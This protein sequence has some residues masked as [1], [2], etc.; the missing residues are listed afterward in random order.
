M[1]P[2]LSFEFETI[3]D[4]QDFLE[5]ASAFI[6]SQKENVSGLVE[7]EPVGEVLTS[8]LTTPNESI[9]QAEVDTPE[10]E[11]TPGDSRH[12]ITR[13]DVHKALRDYKAKNGHPEY[14][15]LLAYFGASGLKDIVK[16]DYKA[17]YDMAMG[18]PTEPGH[19]SAEPVETEPVEVTPQDV[20]NALRDHKNRWGMPATQNLLAHLGYPDPNDIPEEQ[21][22]MVID[23][24]KND[25]PVKPTTGVDLSAF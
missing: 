1:K 17:I 11:I 6:N 22:T 4:A 7:K 10:I 21:Y 25:N 3:E 14:K 12:K 18:L 9:A 8:L 5:Y 15:K 2:K 19:E 13:D 23:A 16:G 24:L 20:I